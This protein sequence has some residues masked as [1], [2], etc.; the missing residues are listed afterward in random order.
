MVG[1][2][3]FSGKNLWRGESLEVQGG[4]VVSDL[5]HYSREVWVGL[6]T[7]LLLVSDICK[8]DPSD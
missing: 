1:L 7:P 8:E 6:L 4:F 2:W 5:L 3:R